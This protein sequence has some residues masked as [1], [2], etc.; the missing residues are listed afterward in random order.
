MQGSGRSNKSDVAVCNELGINTKYLS[1]WFNA[2]AI[3]H[4]PRKDDHLMFKEDETAEYYTQKFADE[5]VCH[6][7]RPPSFHI[8][9]LLS[10]Q[11]NRPD[12]AKRIREIKRGIAGLVLEQAC[13]GLAKDPAEIA[14][15][16]PLL[17]VLKDLLQK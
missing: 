12:G 11:V 16:L 8:K 17:K 10:I 13:I 14:M 9:L 6:P 7:H 4:M 5:R 2:E 3:K 15:C 1:N